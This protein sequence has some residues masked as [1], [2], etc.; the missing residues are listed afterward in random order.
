MP[1]G[2]VDR[3]HVRV[4]E[5]EHVYTQ[6]VYSDR[7]HWLAD[8]P[9]FVGGKILGPDPYEHL[10]AALGACT[11]MTLPGRKASWGTGS[12][13]VMHLVDGCSRPVGTTSV[14]AATSTG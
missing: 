4:E 9:V 2:P 7:H 3:G 8:E 6:D 13:S 11:A 14:S 1:R 5:K 10:L 12:A